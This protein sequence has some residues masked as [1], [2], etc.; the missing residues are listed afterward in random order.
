MGVTAAAKLSG[1]TPVRLD[2]RE[3]TAVVDWCRTDA[4]PFTEPFFDQTVETCFRH[5]FRL[6]FRRET[7]ID[8]LG[9]FAAAHPGLEPA[10]FVF[11]MSR[12]G[13]T[14]VAQMLASSPEH[15]VLSEPPPLDGVLR[16]PHAGPR[17]AWLR[18]MVTALGQP[19][20]PAR[21]L[22]VKFD[23]WSTMHLAV[24]RQAFPEVPWIF[25]FRD[26]V[27]VLV[28]HGRRRGAHVIPAAVPPE[29]FGMAAADVARLPPLDYAAA[30]LARICE[31]ALEWRD[32]PRATFVDYRRL[33]E[34]ASQELLDRWSVHLSPADRRRMLEVAQRDAKNPAIA[35]AGDSSRGGPQATPEIRA[36]ADRW[37]AP[38]YDRLRHAQ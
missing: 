30:V 31:A 26:P 17:A 10:G 33:P 24:V 13:S 11:H 38:A 1:W 21:R 28:S 25:L 4:V 3:G 20:G 18:W 8:E 36:A 22:F 15:L 7:S 19:R 6:L 5:P 16:A 23:A 37:L 2:W 9:A 12:C 32:D 14:L 29:T 35:F 27:E 34:F